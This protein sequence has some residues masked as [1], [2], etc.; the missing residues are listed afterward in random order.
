M[1]EIEDAKGGGQIFWHRAVERKIE[2]VE[3]SG[4]CLEEIGGHIEKHV[5]PIETTFHELVSDII[6]I[7][8][9]IVLPGEEREYYTLVTSGMSDRPM[10]VEVKSEDLRYAEVCI[11]LPAGWLV[12]QQSL[13]D[14]NNYWPI[15]WLKKVARFPH[16]HDTWVALGH[17]VQ[18][19]PPEQFASRTDFTG[20]LIAP[21]VHAGEAF[22]RLEITAGKVINFYGVIPLYQEE[23]DLK[24]KR[25]VNALVE[26]LIKNNV[27]ELVNVR[28][29]N[30]AKRRW[31]P[32]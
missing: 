11:C 26:L 21:A 2:P 17:T 24:L 9:H 29:K 12:D 6:H 8:V 22:S 5:G 16:E 27:T 14:E 4:S 7:D 23:I 18:D 30:L 1:A 13:E 15:R 10:H 31:W 3:M 20:L 25:G 28:R 19:D 32:W